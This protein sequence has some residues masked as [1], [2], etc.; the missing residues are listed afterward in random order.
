MWYV[1]DIRTTMHEYAASFRDLEDAQKWAEEK[2]GEYSFLQL[3]LK[4]PT[5][6]K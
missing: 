6:R 2:F 3:K 5:K 4:H 1:Y